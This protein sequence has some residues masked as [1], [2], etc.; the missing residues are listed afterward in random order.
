MESFRLG[1]NL[2]VF[3]PF[4]FAFLIFAAPIQADL[5]SPEASE[6]VEEHALLLANPDGSIQG[7]KVKMKLSR[8]APAGPGQLRAHLQYELANIS[9]E[10][11]L[12]QAVSKPLPIDGMII[13]DEASVGF[14]F[15]ENPV[16]GEANPVYLKVYHQS[17]LQSLP[18]MVAE[19]GPDRL[20]LEGKGPPVQ[21]PPPPEGGV[22][23]WGPET[24]LRER[25]KPGSEQVSIPVVEATG[26]FLLRLTNGTADGAR[27]VS[28]AVITLNGGEIFR[29]SEF[30]QQVARVKAAG[31]PPAR[32][33]SYGS[34]P[35]ER[36]RLSSHP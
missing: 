17:D 31:C 33:E 32:H 36:A 8:L 18:R 4:I 2:F 26:P 19:F 22:L 35:Q 13:D 28:S 23:I 21:T 12:N 34:Q 30:N 7:V 27:R 29:P 15:T 5:A 20:L 25:G 3:S 14:D 10:W 1:K 9:G 6:S 11:S 16:S 24:F